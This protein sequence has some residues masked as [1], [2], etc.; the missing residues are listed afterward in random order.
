LAELIQVHSAA[1]STM[2]HRNT[3]WEV[4]GVTINARIAVALAVFV[5][6]ASAWALRT[7]VVLTRATAAGG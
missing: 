4:Y 6:S 2:G 5:L 3:G 7:S 1:V